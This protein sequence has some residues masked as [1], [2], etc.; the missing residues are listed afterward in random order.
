MS[1]GIIS[2]IK[3]MTFEHRGHKI[4]MFLV[5]IHYPS[6]PPKPGE[7]AK[8]MWKVIIDNHENPGTKIG[9]REEVLKNLK[10]VIDWLIDSPEIA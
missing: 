9:N 6:H 10:I 4:E 5:G 7:E 2:F 3:D 1:I 8:A